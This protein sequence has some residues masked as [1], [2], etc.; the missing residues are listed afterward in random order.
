MLPAIFLGPTVVKRSL[1]FLGCQ[2]NPPFDFWIADHNEVPWL[3]VGP[4]GRSAGCLDAT[5]DDIEGH[6]PV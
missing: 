5:F 2:S 4:A 6:G 1:F 3:L